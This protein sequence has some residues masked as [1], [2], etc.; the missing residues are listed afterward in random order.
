MNDKIPLKLKKFI[1]WNQ[2]IS[3]SDVQRLLGLGKTRSNDY[4]INLKNYLQGNLVKHGHRYQVIGTLPFA[5]SSSSLLNELLTWK[6]NKSSEEFYFKCNNV[7]IDPLYSPNF[8]NEAI[9]AILSALNQKQAIEIGY[10]DAKPDANEEIRLIRPLALCFVNE[11]WHIHAYC[12]KKADTRDF[13]LSRITLASKPVKLKF[14]GLAASI[15]NMQQMISITIAAHPNLTVNQK[16]VVER[17]YEIENSV[18]TI[19]IPKHQLFYF[20]KKYLAENNEGPP[21]KFLIEITN[22]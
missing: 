6:K 11:R 14:P 2:S 8:N 12:Y 19:Q 20:K 7:Y 5:F 1:F 10:V 21:N 22:R 3:L 13:V 15:Q 4:F 9:K 16:S 18:R 17:E